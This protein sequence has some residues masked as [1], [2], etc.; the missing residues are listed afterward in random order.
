DKIIEKRKNKSEFINK[1]KYSNLFDTEEIFDANATAW[2]IEKDY[3]AR[4]YENYKKL[5]SEFELCE[6][7]YAEKE[8]SIKLLSSE[9][10]ELKKTAKNV[11]IPAD[12]IN[13]LLKATFPYKKL[14]LDDSGDE[15]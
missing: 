11:K 6:K 9:L 12:R 8:A 10:K 15:V 4:E 5:K 14:E 2:D 3:V 1:V 13:L 7:E